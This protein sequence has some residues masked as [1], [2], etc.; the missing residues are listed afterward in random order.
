MHGEHELFHMFR[1]LSEGEVLNMKQD[2]PS[3]EGNKRIVVICVE[4]SLVQLVLSIRLMVDP[5]SDVH[6]AT[7]ASVPAS[8]CKHKLLSVIVHLITTNFAPI[9]N[10]PTLQ[11]KP[12]GRIP[13][14]NNHTHNIITRRQPWFPMIINLAIAPQQQ[15]HQVKGLYDT[16]L[17]TST[18]WKAFLSQRHY[19][20]RRN[21]PL[22]DRRLRLWRYLNRHL[23]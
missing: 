14:H 15:Q 13:F 8:K 12:L 9:S 2:K 3:L 6:A 20:L 19:L 21:T 18:D 7:S 17:R 22:M 5:A 16:Q 23:L 11:S 4:R 10:D 1:T